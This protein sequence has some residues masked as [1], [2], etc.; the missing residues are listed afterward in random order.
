MCTI[1]RA[2]EKEAAHTSERR[3]HETNNRINSKRRVVKGSMCDVV[4]VDVHK[5]GESAKWFIIRE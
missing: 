3:E 1:K 4:I 5:Q 2:H